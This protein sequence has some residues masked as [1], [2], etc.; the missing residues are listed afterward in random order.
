MIT[1]NETKATIKRRADKKWEL[2]CGSGNVYLCHSRAFA[3]T[4][5]AHVLR[6]PLCKPEAQPLPVA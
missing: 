3:R 2:H 1:C 5:R 6:L 4:L